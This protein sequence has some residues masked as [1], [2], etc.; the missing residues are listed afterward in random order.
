MRKKIRQQ[1]RDLRSNLPSRPQAAV[2]TWNPTSSQGRASPN[3]SSGTSA[4]SAGHEI[5]GS[6]EVSNAHAGPIPGDLSASSNCSASNGTPGPDLWKEAMEELKRNC[7]KD[8]SWIEDNFPGDALLAVPAGES[9]NQLIDLVGSM[10]KKSQSESWQQNLKVFGKE[11]KLNDVASNTITWL[12][13]FI[14]VG[15]TAVQYDPAHAAL[16]WALFRF[17]LQSAVAMDERMKASLVVAERASRLVHRCRIYEIMFLEETGELDKELITDLRRRLIELYSMLLQMLASTGRFMQKNRLGSVVDAILDPEHGSKLLQDLDWNEAE[18]DKQANICDARHRFNTNRKLLTLL[19]L[20]EPILR[21]DENVTAMLETLNAGEMASIRRWISTTAYGQHH[22]LIRTRR[23]E[24]TGGWVLKTAEFVEWQ[25]CPESSVFWLRGTAGT[26]KTYCTSR[27]IDELESTLAKSHTNEGLAFFYSSHAERDRGDC[28]MVLRSFVRQL[29][30]PAGAQGFLHRDLREL[31]RRSIE[32]ESQWTIALCVEWLTKLVGFYHRTTLV[33]DALDECPYDQRRELLNTLIL[34]AKPER[35]VKIFITSRPE[36][37]I[38]RRLINL[39]NVEISADRNSEDVAKLVET[40]LDTSDPSSA[41]YWSDALESDPSLK[42]E[43]RNTLIKRHEGMFQWAWLQIQGLRQLGDAMGIR[44]RLGRLPEDLDKTY[45]EIYQRIERFPSHIRERT[46][47]ALKW[48]FEAEEP[49]TTRQLL[50]AVCIDVEA[51]S[52]SC[53]HNTTE[54]DLHEWCANLLRLDMHGWQ[55]PTWRASH[56]SVVEFFRKANVLGDIGCFMAS[57]QLVLFLSLPIGG[58]EHYANPTQHDD[59]VGAPSKKL[60]PHRNFLAEDGLYYRYTTKY[61]VRHVQKQNQPSVDTSKEPLARLAR[62][63]RRFLGLPLRSSP[64]YRAWLLSNVG[65]FHMATEWVSKKKMWPCEASV[66][67]ASRLGLMHLVGKAWWED[68]GNGLL[69]VTNADNECL[70]TLA[71][72]S[73]AVAL[74]EFLLGQGL[75]VNS[76]A[77]N[78]GALLLAA[79]ENL[80]MAMVNL[81]LSRGADVHQRPHGRPTVLSAI[82][83]FSRIDTSRS[84]SVALE[85]LDSLLAAGADPNQQAD[86]FGNALIAAAINGNLS[87]V[88]RLLA[89]GADPNQKVGRIGS[90]LAAAASWDDLPMI[91][92][93]LAAGADPSQQLQEGELSGSALVV[94]AS[95]GH[96]Q[97]VDRLL[98]AG[99]DPNQQLHACIYGSPL[100]AAALG[101]HL[102]TIH[103]LL[104]AGADPNQQLQ[105]GGYGSALA[106]AAY[107]CKD[108]RAEVMET[109]LKAGADP[110]RQLD[111]YPGNAL[112]ASALSNAPFRTAKILLNYGAQADVTTGVGLLRTPLIAAAFRGALTTVQLLIS[113]GAQINRIVPGGAFRTALEASQAE[114]TAQYFPN[115]FM[116]SHVW[117]ERELAKAK[118]ETRHWLIQNGALL[119]GGQ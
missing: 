61:W 12:N 26:G 92:R 53:S 42:D 104:A 116:P 113:S 13:K 9:I 36:G 84:I 39:P 112:I 72:R 2:A 60:A 98:I 94:A 23:V 11:V 15:D 95:R 4:A 101:G 110:N 96:I 119:E 87:M 21:T 63:L 57:A 58:D 77:E 89:A 109:L 93:L 27:V 106:A 99:A 114:V 8:W 41:D 118:A 73:G 46:L 7:T 24:E 48:V 86:I 83:G 25:R 56:F 49:L 44:E 47:R 71:V 3:A 43:I 102:Y 78:M 50:D 22:D 115:Q 90:A 52:L 79:A 40:S 76:C 30:A 35:R 19:D 14:A 103:R 91:D 108:S 17:I 88:D 82:A 105:V 18:L 34:L 85:I 38:R 28:L 5:S 29:S 74:C 1:I 75:P 59:Q 69:Q 32:R 16:P 81:L 51:E 10:I 65:G 6:T 70:L 54:R 80:D 20:Q 55:G 107:H 66:I 97:A 100:A 62:L 45:E 33:L 37:D 111:I 64:H 68:A 117:D 67:G 31:H